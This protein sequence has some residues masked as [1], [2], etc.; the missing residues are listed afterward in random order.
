MY[1]VI[2]IAAVLTV[3]MA[4]VALN[5]DV[6]KKFSVLSIVVLIVGFGLLWIE[7]SATANAI[8]AKRSLS[9]TVDAV[10]SLIL[11]VV[12]EDNAD[13]RFDYDDAANIFLALKVYSPVSLNGMEVDDIV[14]QT[15]VSLPQVISKELS[16]RYKTRIAINVFLVLLT[17]CA[18]YFFTAKTMQGTSKGRSTRRYDDEGYSRNTRYED[19]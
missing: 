2:L 16:C 11:Q 14:G 7:L 1:W 18:L 19:F 8:R 6:R 17:L 9:E 15:I 4:V 10:S 3:L 12:G 5:T 13:Y